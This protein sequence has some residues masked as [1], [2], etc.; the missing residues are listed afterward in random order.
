MKI[1]AALIAAASALVVATPAAAN[2]WRLEA[3]GG[4]AWANGVEKAIAGAALG[5]D[6]DLGET[7]FAGIETSI[8]KILDG[9]ASLTFGATARAGAKIGQGKLYATGGYSFGEGEDTWTAGAGYQHK[10]GSNAYLKAEYR[11]FFSVV[12]INVVA[13]GVGVAF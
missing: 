3:R 12:D 13:A 7:A 9:D 6:A 8:D 5:Y 10:V 4:V 11:R 2:E 1:Q